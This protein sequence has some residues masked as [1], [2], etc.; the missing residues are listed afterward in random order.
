MDGTATYPVCAWQGFPCAHGTVSRVRT[1][2]YPL[3]AWEDILCAH[4]KVSY[5]LTVD[6]TGLWPLIPPDAG[7][8][9]EQHPRCAG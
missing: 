1:G 7:E 4:G 5:V 9:G 2:R 3:C 6:R 8:R